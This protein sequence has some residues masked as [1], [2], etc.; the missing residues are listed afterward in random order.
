MSRRFFDFGGIS[1]IF[2]G[3][4]RR[5]V[6][7][8]ERFAMA[9]VRYLLIKLVGHLHTDDVINMRERNSFNFIVVYTLGNYTKFSHEIRS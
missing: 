1:L 9:R 8:R 5:E 4:K 3:Y 7:T 2:C 6:I